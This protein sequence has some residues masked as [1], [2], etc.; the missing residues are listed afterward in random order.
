VLQGL[1]QTF[2]GL[3]ASR[4]DQSDPFRELLTEP[5]TAIDSATLRKLVLRGLHAFGFKRE[6]LSRAV[7][8]K[9]NGDDSV[10]IRFP[11]TALACKAFRR[12]GVFL[13]PYP[14]IHLNPWYPPR[15]KPRAPTEEELKCHL[16]KL[17]DDLATEE[18]DDAWDPPS[19]TV[20][21]PPSPAPP[22]QARRATED[23]ALQG[24][25]TTGSP[26]DGDQQAAVPDASSAMEGVTSPNAKRAPGPRREGALSAS[27]PHKRQEQS[28]ASAEERMT[29]QRP[30]TAPAAARGGGGGG[31]SSM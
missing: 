17:Q 4:C 12:K 5:L 25:T 8:V 24:A 21:R 27:P 20:S 6:D 10:L 30:P 1:Q 11:D 9:V 13:Q 15:P 31:T 18:N 28:N 16:A 14:D 26:T 19:P 3:F 22:S 23:Q 29:V 7:E 2:K